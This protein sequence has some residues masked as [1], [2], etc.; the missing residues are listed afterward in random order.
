MMRQTLGATRS[1]AI[2]PCLLAISPSCLFKLRC[3]RR[4][5]SL[6]LRISIDVCPTVAIRSLRGSRCTVRGNKC[7]TTPSDEGWLYLTGHKDLYTREIVRLRYG[8]TYKKSL[9]TK[10]LLQA[11]SMKRPEKGLIHH[12]DRGSQ[13]CAHD[14]HKILSF[15]AIQPL[16][17]WSLSLKGSFG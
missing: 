14:Y 7:H 5:S 9:V 2:R 3:S 17:L 15:F 13:Y 10:S 1:S 4:V 8:S 6:N 12:S 16:I 11:V